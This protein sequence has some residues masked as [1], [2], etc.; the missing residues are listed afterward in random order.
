VLNRQLF[1]EDLRWIP[2]SLLGA[3]QVHLDA[4]LKEP[5]LDSEEEGETP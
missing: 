1:I 5:K 4:I 3:G 2:R